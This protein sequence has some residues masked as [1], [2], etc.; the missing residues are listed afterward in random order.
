MLSACHAYLLYR[1]GIAIS[2]VDNN[3]KVTGIEN[4]NKISIFNAHIAHFGNGKSY[5]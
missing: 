4:A 3:D 5:E 2:C 1:S